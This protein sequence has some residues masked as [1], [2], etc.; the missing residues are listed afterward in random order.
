MTKYFRDYINDLPD[1]EE[2]DINRVLGCEIKNGIIEYNFDYN[3]K[4]SLYDLFYQSYN[5]QP[6]RSVLLAYSHY[7]NNPNVCEWPIVAT[8]IREY[9]INNHGS[10][11]KFIRF[12]KPEDRK[13]LYRE[14]V[15]SDKDFDK[16]TIVFLDAEENDKIDIDLLLDCRSLNS[17]CVSKLTKEQM[18]E[19]VYKSPKFLKYIYTYYTCYLNSG[20]GFTIL[21]DEDK[22]F[23]RELFFNKLHPNNRP[24]FIRDCFNHTYNIK[25]FI[26]MILTVDMRYAQ[27]FSLDNS[28][29]VTGN[30]INLY[31]A[32]REDG[33]PLYGKTIRQWLLLLL[34]Y[35]ANE[36][37]L[38]KHIKNYLG[39][40]YGLMELYGNYVDV[41]KNVYT[42]P[43]ISNN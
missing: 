1:Y 35:Q 13:K 28:S 22:M 10:I 14:L 43:I 20:R 38:T 6:L 34:Y 15:N 18:C 31:E 25:D 29:V 36:L 23:L 30:I 37:K 3:E 19:C 33:E 4:E 17:R 8:C 24:D 5:D 26:D 12:I 41:A 42:S 39:R 2:R 32:K 7:L 16:A 40:I 9:I 21:S 27:Y 11:N